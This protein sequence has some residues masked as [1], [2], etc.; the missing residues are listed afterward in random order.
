MPETPVCPK[1]GS[2]YILREHLA[3]VTEYYWEEG[4]RWVLLYGRN[5]GAFHFLC[6]D[7]KHE[8]DPEPIV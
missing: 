7:C 6:Q 3:K 5:A 4:H 2:I 8:W 1:C